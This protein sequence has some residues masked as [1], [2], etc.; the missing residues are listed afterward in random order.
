MS[1]NITDYN[2]ANTNLLFKQINSTCKFLR[3]CGFFYNPGF[4]IDTKSYDTSFYLVIF[5]IF[6]KSFFLNQ[7]TYNGI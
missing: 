5:Y 6:Y 3:A 1:I 7:I 4:V 2:L